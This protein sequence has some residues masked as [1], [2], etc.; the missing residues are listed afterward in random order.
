MERIKRFFRYDNIGLLFALPAFIYMLVFVGYPIISNII[1]SLQDVTVANL[2]RG[3]KHFIGLE[4]YVKVLNIEAET[5]LS[6]ARMSRSRRLHSTMAT[7]QA[8]AVS[9][10]AMPAGFPTPPSVT[11]D[12]STIP[13]SA[14]ATQGSFRRF[15]RSRSTRGAARITIRGAM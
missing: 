1:L 2:S 7:K 5:A 4:N 15:K 6:M 11:P 3:E 8:A 14:A 12:T 9:P 10:R 13:A